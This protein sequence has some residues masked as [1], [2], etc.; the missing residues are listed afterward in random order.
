MRSLD[1]SVMLIKE[2]FLLGLERRHSESGKVKPLLP[3]K[4]LNRG[5]EKT[6]FLVSWPHEICNDYN[7]SKGMEATSRC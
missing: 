2:D 3:R 6:R 5:N 1:F 7:A 4:Y